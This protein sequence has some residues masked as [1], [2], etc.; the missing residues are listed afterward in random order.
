M[1]MRFRHIKFMVSFF[2]FIFS[3]S[4]HSIVCSEF[5]KARPKDP[6]NQIRPDLIGKIEGIR[7]EHAEAFGPL[8]HKLKEIVKESSARIVEIA[9]Y[10]SQK[11]RVS[12]YGRL[13]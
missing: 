7:A 8:V 3:L 12:R 9:F 5:L 2:A 11:L 1:K 4:A 13:Q 6:V 10:E